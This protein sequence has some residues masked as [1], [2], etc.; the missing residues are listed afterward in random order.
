MLLGIAGKCPIL[1]FRIKPK[2]ET[3]RPSPPPPPAFLP[4]PL[5]PIP[6]DVEMSTNDP[7]TNQFSTSSTVLPV[8]QFPHQ[9]ETESEEQQTNTLTRIGINTGKQTTIITPQVQEE[10]AVSVS[11]DSNLWVETWR[12]LL[13]SMDLGLGSVWGSNPKIQIR[14]LF[15]MSK[16]RRVP[17]NYQLYGIIHILYSFIYYFET[18]P[19][20]SFMICD[21]TGLGK[22]TM[23]ILLIAFSI[24]L[25]QK[26]RLR[27]PMPPGDEDELRT[28]L[29]SQPIPAVPS[30]DSEFKVMLES[31]KRSVVHYGFCMTPNSQGRGFRCLLIVNLVLLEDPWRKEIREIFGDDFSLFIWHNHYELRNMTVEEAK[32]ALERANLVITTPEMIKNDFKVW[33]MG[34]SSAATKQSL[35]FTTFWDLVLVDEGH[36]LKNM[37]RMDLQFGKAVE[38]LMRN[39]WLIITASALGN[40][41]E[42]MGSYWK[43][44]QHEYASHPYMGRHPSFLNDKERKEQS[45][46][47]QSFFTKYAIKRRSEDK[48]L[49][50]KPKKIQ[51][52]LVPF[53][54]EQKV[55]QELLLS[56]LK[57]YHT[58]FDQVRAE[59]AVDKKKKKKVVVNSPSR[60]RPQRTTKKRHKA[61][62]QEDDDEDEDFLQ[63]VHEPLD[64]LFQSEGDVDEEEPP[65]AENE[66]EEETKVVKK[67]RVTGG[68]IEGRRRKSGSSGRKRVFQ[69]SLATGILQSFL[70]YELFTCNNPL[71][72]LSRC[73]YKARR[74]LEALNTAKLDSSNRKQTQQ[75][76]HHLSGFWASVLQKIAKVRCDLTGSGAPSAIHPV[77]SLPVT[78]QMAPRYAAILRE[79]SAHKRQYPEDVIAIFSPYTLV[80]HDLAEFFAKMILQDRQFAHL[81]FDKSPNLLVGSTECGIGI[82]QAVQTKDDRDKQQRLYG[83]LQNKNQRFAFI[84]QDM[85]CK[86]VPKCR[87]G[88]E[89]S[90]LNFR[91]LNLQWISEMAAEYEIIPSSPSHTTTTR[92]FERYRRRWA[93]TVMTDDDYTASTCLVLPLDSETFFDHYDPLRPFKIIENYLI[94]YEFETW[95]YLQLM[96]GIEEATRVIQ[97]LAAGNM[98]DLVTSDNAWRWNPERL[99]WDRNEPLSLQPLNIEYFGNLLCSIVGRVQSGL[100]QDS[101]NMAAQSV[102]DS[103]QMSELRALLKKHTN[104]WR[105]RF[106]ILFHFYLFKSRLIDLIQEAE[107][108]QYFKVIFSKLSSRGGGGESAAIMHDLVF[109][110]ETFCKWSHLL[111]CLCMVLSEP[112]VVS[113]PSPSV[114]STTSSV[115]R[116]VLVFAQFYFQIKLF[117]TSLL[118]LI[119][120]AKHERTRAWLQFLDQDK[121]RSTPKD[122]M[123]FWTQDIFDRDCIL[124]QGQSQV[125]QRSLEIFDQKRADSSRLSKERQREA[126]FKVFSQYRKMFPIKTFQT[127]VLLLSEKLTG[128]GKTFAVPS[129]CIFS[130]STVAPASLKQAIDRFCR[131]GQTGAVTIMRFLSCFEEKMSVEE[132][133]KWGPTIDFYQYR[134]YE[135]P[136]TWMQDE[137]LY[138]KRPED[139]TPCPKG[140]D[141]ITLEDLK[142]FERIRNIKSSSRPTA[143][144]HQRDS[145]SSAPSTS[146]PMEEEQ[147]PRTPQIPP[148]KKRISRVP[149]TREVTPPSSPSP[150]PSP[151]STQDLTAANRRYLLQNAVTRSF[152]CIY[153]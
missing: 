11:F 3:P 12:N 140:L 71:L 117:Y 24:S 95:N 31:F 8:Q 50:P 57:D 19:G 121:P 42:E 23:A 134:K 36:S 118:W 151:S 128:F 94:W 97:G 65:P 102:K 85:F 147:S 39:R 22:T 142:T 10:R 35:L 113:Q 2:I 7:F 92:T 52:F 144:S 137:Y 98:F 123:Q 53:S 133:Q 16:I 136:K 129:L 124:G 63:E 56:L 30:N 54:K 90:S 69:D 67:K 33:K 89:A 127:S 27:G 1:D 38:E 115:F 73:E 26:W 93:S 21:G 25:H 99:Q 43:L 86:M 51:F 109:P 18:E 61:Q 9:S 141:Q 84:L 75:L 135:C 120:G 74:D 131:I 153:Q 37:I 77:L 111:G 72:A 79:I 78:A 143:S 101:C 45:A 49:W 103:K 80:L 108:V 68:G 59:R 66:E 17:L 139:F 70:M 32:N 87:L 13:T 81:N 46:A 96:E 138:N 125:A 149:V 48:N 130:G 14:S 28:F 119:Y 150:A 83:Y 44:F 41:V 100:Q 152:L 126:E 91:Q 20:F 6:Q 112:L 58:L 62:E 122:W 64:T 106:P 146:A 82:V 76:I 4:L 5:P 15:L 104:V 114:I 88:T 34:S 116:S 60:R 110:Q 107:L 145:V 29:K 47:I 105:A 40:S 148:P 55:V 132:K